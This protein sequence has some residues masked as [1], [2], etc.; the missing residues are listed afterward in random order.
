[1]AKK[2]S[3]PP[4]TLD[5]S[6]IV[7]YAV[8]PKT[9]KYAIGEPVG[10]SE[11]LLFHCDDKWKVASTSSHPSVRQAKQ[12][13]ERENPGIASAWTRDGLPPIEC[14]FCGRKSEQ[15]RQMIAKENVRIC[16]ICVREAHAKL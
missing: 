3:G 11:V 6:R 10:D 14:S 16:D 15:V 5:G 8:I 13:A 4:T 12:R 7:E 2:S 9:A 1:V